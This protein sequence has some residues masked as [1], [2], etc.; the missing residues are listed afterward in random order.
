MK[1][2]RN[3]FDSAKLE[4]CIKLLSELKT[5]EYEITYSKLNQEEIDKGYTPCPY[6]NYKYPEE[7]YEVDEL[8]PDD[9][10]YPENVENLPF[11]GEHII[12]NVDYS[13]L[14]IDNIRTI[15]TALFEHERF[16]EGMIARGVNKGIFLNTLLRLKYLIENE[17]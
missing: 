17:K 9:Y 6:V 10:D 12:D 2:D 7:L 8:L 14:T 16:G 13:K 5:I 15:L 4:R 3:K 11:I 1:F